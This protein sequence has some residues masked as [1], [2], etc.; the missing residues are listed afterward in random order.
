MNVK[1]ILLIP[2]ARKSI[3][4]RKMYGA[5]VI[6]FRWLAKIKYV[7]INNICSQ[8]ISQ[9]SLVPEGSALG[10]ICFVLIINDLSKCIKYSIFKLFVNNIKL[11]FSFVVISSLTISKETRMLLQ[12]RQGY[13][14]AKYVHK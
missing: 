9:L 13:I 6:C 1:S 4:K 5:S 12:I 8:N 10:P 7:K 2:L 11:Y 3:L 14:L